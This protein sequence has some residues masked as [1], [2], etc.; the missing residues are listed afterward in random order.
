MLPGRCFPESL[1]LPATASGFV[2]LL[3]LF[4]VLGLGLEPKH[5]VL[6]R[7]RSPLSCGP[8]FFSPVPIWSAHSGVGLRLRPG[9]SPSGIHQGAVGRPPP[10]N[11]S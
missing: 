11:P 10:M 7:K 6:G 5:L 9:A 4:V 8:A 3:Y 2:N 1:I